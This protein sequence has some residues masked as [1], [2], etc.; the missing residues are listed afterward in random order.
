MIAISNDCMRDHWLDLLEA[1]PFLRWKTTQVSPSFTL[2]LARF[3]HF[4]GMH[5]SVF[6]TIGIFDRGQY[7][8]K[9][10]LQ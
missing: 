5:V 8:S 6:L 1:R 4:P 2:P 7:T 3:S 10:L 9:S